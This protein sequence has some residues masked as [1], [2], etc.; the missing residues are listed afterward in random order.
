MFP[1]LRLRTARARPPAPP[2]GDTA[3]CIGGTS[4][5]PYRYG[6]PERR[7]LRGGVHRL[8]GS[9][10]VRAKPQQTSET[11]GRLCLVRFTAAMQLGEL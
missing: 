3:R 7:E 4:P 11:L 10:L 5:N 9:L 8:A 6:V 2:P 1:A